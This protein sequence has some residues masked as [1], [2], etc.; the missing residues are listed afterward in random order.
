MGW[1][2]GAS[3][4][5]GCR[6]H[7]RTGG[8]M[9]RGNFLSGGKLVRRRWQRAW[10]SEFAV[11]AGDFLAVFF[12][13]EIEGALDE[14]IVHFLDGDLARLGA[15]KKS[16]AAPIGNRVHFAE[17]ARLADVVAHAA[18]NEGYGDGAVFAVH[19][20]EA[21]VRAVGRHFGG[22]PFFAIDDGA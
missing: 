19:R 6:W 10:N 11:C 12:G 22:L 5:S 20:D 17:V 2:K 3:S 8:R 9:G 4:R 21:G 15:D 18:D 13:G 7:P 16:A 1:A 14:L